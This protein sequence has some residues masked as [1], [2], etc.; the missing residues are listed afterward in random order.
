MSTRGTPRPTAGRK[1]KS[2]ELKVLYG[3]AKK[4]AKGSTAAVTVAPMTRPKQPQHLETQGKRAWKRLVECLENEGRLDEKYHDCLEQTA[5]LI[6]DWHDSRRAVHKYGLILVTIDQAGN[7]MHRRN[8]ADVAMMDR[9]KAI[10]GM[11]AELGLTPAS[12]DRL[13]RELEISADEKTAA[14]FLG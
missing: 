2:D 14:R 6:Q 3:S 13:A 7:E 12:G 10:K 9:H 8:P 1:P 4:P 11:L 5:Q